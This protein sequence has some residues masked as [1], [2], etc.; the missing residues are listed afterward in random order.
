MYYKLDKLVLQN[1]A[2][3]FYYNFWQTLLQIGTDQL[4]QVSLP[5][6]KTGNLKG[7]FI[8]NWG[9]YLKHFYLLSQIGTNIL[10]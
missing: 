8:S 2:A 4:G 9:K 10:N 3:F 5:T 1:L 7:T 6:V